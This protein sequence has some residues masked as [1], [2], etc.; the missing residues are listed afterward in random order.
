MEANSKLN[1]GSTECKFACSEIRKY[2]KKYFCISNS[3]II[4]RANNVYL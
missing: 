3:K 4:K 1:S 2:V